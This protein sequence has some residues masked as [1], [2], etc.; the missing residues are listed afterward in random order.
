M[1]K[2]IAIASGIAALSSVFALPAQAELYTNFYNNTKQALQITQVDLGGG[3]M[4]TNAKVGLEIKPQP[5]GYPP[6]IW[7]D[8]KGVVT[9]YYRLVVI[10]DKDNPNNSCRFSIPYTLVKGRRGHLYEAFFTAGSYK[11]ESKGN[12]LCYIND[13]NGN[14]AHLN[15]FPK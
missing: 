14:T 4:E 7:F 15:L 3:G 13:L 5:G 12:L 6:H 10:S 8:A 9:N 1:I 2:K 11:I